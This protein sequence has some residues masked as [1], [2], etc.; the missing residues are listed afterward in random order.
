MSRRRKSEKKAFAPDP[1]F[2]SALVT[3]FVNNVVRRGKRRLAERLFYDAIEIIGQRTGGQDAIG[4]FKKA[5]DNVKPVLEVK[6]RRIGGAN[7]QVP[8]EVPSDRRV[9]LAIRWLINYSKERSEKS[10]AEKLA[11]EFMQASKNEG[12]AVHK[13]IDTHKMAEANKA[14]AHFRW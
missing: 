11:N 5:V 10:M 8:I 7:Y 13:K 9:S 4:V 1:K 14:F 2:K 3:Q 12:G 6:S